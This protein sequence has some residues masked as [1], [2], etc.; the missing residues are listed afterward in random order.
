MGK[1]VYLEN[2]YPCNYTVIYGVELYYICELGKYSKLTFDTSISVKNIQFDIEKLEQTVFWDYFRVAISQEWLCDFETDALDFYVSP[3]FPPQET[4]D[5]ILNDFYVFEDVPFDKAEF[6]KR[7]EDTIYDYITPHKYKVMLSK[8]TKQGWLWQLDDN[9]VENLYTYN[10][11]AICHSHTEQALVSLVAKVAVERHFNSVPEVFFMQFTQG[12]M[13]EP[14][15]LAYVYM[16]YENTNCFVNFQYSTV[17]FNKRKLSN[18]WVYLQIA[19]TVEPKVRIQQEYFTWYA[20]H[21]PTNIKKQTNSEKLAYMQQLG[22]EEGDMVVVYR[23]KKSQKY[24]Y[25]KYIAQA[26]F[27]VIK[28]I[29]ATTIDLDCYSITKL[30]NTKILEYEQLTKEEKGRLDYNNYVKPSHKSYKILIS[31]LSIQDKVSDEL[32]IIGKPKGDFANGVVDT[33]LSDNYGNNR[34]KHKIRLIEFIYWAFIDYDIDFN[35]G[36]F[37]DEYFGDKVPLKLIYD[38]E[39]AYIDWKKELSY[40][41]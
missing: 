18:Y 23:R 3:Q 8:Q 27:G 36:K 28:S 12:L 25:V 11:K 4:L 24:N 5:T 2:I 6:E 15:N 30:K 19:D 29:N 32:W 35:E 31:E 9:T 37:I 14:L 22:I 38:D 41:C 26:Y 33:E 40:E 17:P 13:L 10:V 34:C 39:Y 20:K 21:V 7:K 1:R 16:L